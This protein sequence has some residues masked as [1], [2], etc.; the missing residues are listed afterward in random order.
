MN[1]S[2]GQLIYKSEIN[3]KTEKQCATD[4]IING[5]IRSAALDRYLAQNLNADIIVTRQ[6]DG[7]TKISVVSSDNKKPIST[8]APLQINNKRFLMNIYKQIE[9]YVTSCRQQ[10]ENLVEEK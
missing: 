10:A 1:I 2:F 8:I 9:E 4:D 6:N 5:I 3:K 7:N